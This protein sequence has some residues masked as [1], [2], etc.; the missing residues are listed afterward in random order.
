[1]I[2]A[3]PS[4]SSVKSLYGELRSVLASVRWLKRLSV[5]LL[6]VNVLLALGLWFARN[7]QTLGF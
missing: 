3:L 7:P 6:V 2:T 1:M 5:A 4:E